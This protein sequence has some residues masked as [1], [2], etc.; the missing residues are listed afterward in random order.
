MK[1]FQIRGL[2]A[3]SDFEI[4]KNPSLNLN[5]VSKNDFKIWEFGGE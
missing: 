4:L 1:G 2:N 3:I 5:T